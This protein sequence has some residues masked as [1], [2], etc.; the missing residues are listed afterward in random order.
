MNIYRVAWEI[1]CTKEWGGH[2][3]N[4]AVWFELANTARDARDLATETAG[5]LVEQMQHVTP[6]KKSHIKI[7]LT[8]KDVIG[9]G[10]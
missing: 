8:A 3:V 1:R 9:G 2:V 4:E 6:P 7:H 5:I 10:K